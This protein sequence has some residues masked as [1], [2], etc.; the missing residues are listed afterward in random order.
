MNSPSARICK[1][2]HTRR[3]LR[4]ASKRQSSI[5]CRRFLACLS[6]DFLRFTTDLD[7]QRLRGNPHKMASLLCQSWRRIF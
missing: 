6:D 4:N 3:A 1:S 5:G 7:V 2:C